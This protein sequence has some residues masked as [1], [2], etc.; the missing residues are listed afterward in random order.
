MDYKKL[1][2]LRPKDFGLIG[3]AGYTG[4]ETDT[5]KFPGDRTYKSI[6]RER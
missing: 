5:S 6:F 4:E 1:V 2:D 3:G